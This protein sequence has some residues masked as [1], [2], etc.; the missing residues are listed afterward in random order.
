M[1]RNCLLLISIQMFFVFCLSA[2]PKE[3][4]AEFY[5]EFHRGG[6]MRPDNT[7]FYFSKDLSYVKERRDRK[8]EILCFKTDPVL[9]RNLYETL[10]KNR[11]D[12]IE[13]RKETIYD[14][15]GESVQV[16]IDRETYNK[17]DAGMTLIRSYWKSN[18]KNVLDEI[19]KTKR[20]S[21]DGSP[22]IRFSLTWKDFQEPLSLN[23][24]SEKRTLF[25][26]YH[27][28]PSRFDEIGFYFLP[29]KYKLRLE[30]HEDKAKFYDYEIEF[31]INRD[32][33]D[34]SFRCSPEGCVRY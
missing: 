1:L 5:L 25:Y 20:L 32:S 29:G 4:P 31:E 26:S 27:V 6:G 3:M 16:G 18:W 12:R 19:K 7:E 15:G 28:Q 23:I 14:R 24:G 2:L 13:T 8:E 30:F 11:F 21:V 17:S 33:K 22:K 10:V 34:V 9:F